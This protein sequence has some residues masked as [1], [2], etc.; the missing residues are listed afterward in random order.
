MHK[1]KNISFSVGIMC[2][3]EAQN[4]HH[5][6]ASLRKQTCWKS[7]KQIIIVSSG[8]TDDTN[9]IVKKYRKKYPK[10]EL[11]TEGSRYGKAHAVN[12]FLSR[13]LYDIVVLTSADVLPKHNTLALLT[14]HFKDKTVG[15]V[16]SHPI[17]L[18]N[19]DTFLGFA[20]HLL[21]N[22]HHQISLNHPKMGEVIAF[23]K[24]FQKIPVL[25]AVD[26][27][28]IEALVRGQGYK[29]IYEPR[30]IVYNKG[31]ETL[32]EFISRRRS[33]Y[34]G[35]IA[36]KYEYSYSVSTLNNIE[37]SRILLKD[38]NLSLKYIVF[39][40]GTVLLEIVSRVLGYIDY[41]FKLKDHA[42]WQIAVSTKKV[43]K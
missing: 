12:E 33:N 16:G 8:S 7:I 42:I 15:I 27:V 34:F 5:L 37:V 29:A 41:Q 19:H 21:W 24:I 32:R 28:N 26:E 30:A 38:F 14:S 1:N 9:K 4:I 25:S 17:P 40:S 31:P 43:K 23:R 18:N 13:V 36:T 3:N 22:L 20:V 6:L 35:H 2:Y 10:I 39:L 11:I